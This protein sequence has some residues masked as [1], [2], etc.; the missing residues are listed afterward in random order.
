MKKIVTLI[1]AIAIAATAMTGCSN[2]LPTISVSSEADLLTLKVGCQ[3][4]TTGETWLLD[5]AENAP[6]SYKSGMDAALELKN[7]KLD[8]ILLDELPAK[9]IVDQNDDLQIIDLNMEPEKYAIAIAKGNTELQESINSTIA[10]MKEDGS[11]EALTN[12]FMP[13]DGNIV[14]PDD[15]AAGGDKT[16]TVGTNAAFKPFEYVE[17]DKI[18]GFDITMSQQ[19]AADFGATL[20]VS[21]MEFDSLIAA[22]QAGSID[23]IA[24]GMSVTEKRLESV[25]FSDTYYESKQVVIV[26]K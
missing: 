1:A 11:Y 23:M 6:Q 18:V 15:I 3:S 13:V 21:N 26:R 8:A 2:S 16:L 25:D 4:G 9:S 24:A 12:A 22:L 19:I 5:N 7:G 14:I 17:G 20:V 10:K